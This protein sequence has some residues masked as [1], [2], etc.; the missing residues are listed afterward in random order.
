[1]LAKDLIFFKKRTIYKGVGGNLQNMLIDESDS[2]CASNWQN[3][4]CG[5]KV[6][7]EQQ[8]V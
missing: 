3:G 8:E 6:S 7:A 5:E 1:M 4:S 2:L